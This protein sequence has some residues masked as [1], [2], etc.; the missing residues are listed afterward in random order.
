CPG[1]DA[2]GDPSPGRVRGAG[3]AEPV[4]ARIAPRSGDGLPEVPGEGAAQALRQRP[5]PGRGPGPLSGGQVDS[6]TPCGPAG[7]RLALVPAQPGA[8]GSDGG[9][10][11]VAG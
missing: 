7:A 8:G 3:A 9:R 5:G 11:H 1:G 6:G 10:G 4:T 2:S